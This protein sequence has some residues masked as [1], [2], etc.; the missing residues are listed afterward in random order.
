MLLLPIRTQKWVYLGFES[1]DN[2]LTI[3]SGPTFL[4]PSCYTAYNLRDSR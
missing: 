4:D 3:P 2:V 1:L